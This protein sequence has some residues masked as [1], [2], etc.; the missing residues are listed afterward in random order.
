M[1]ALNKFSAERNKLLKETKDLDEVNKC[2]FTPKIS[3][4]SK[5][6]IDKNEKNMNLNFY[7][8]NMIWIDIMKK[9]KQ[10][11]LVNIQ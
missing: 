4:I 1:Q 9:S 2:S 7:E 5:R 11:K 3:N 6:P 10:E 8:K